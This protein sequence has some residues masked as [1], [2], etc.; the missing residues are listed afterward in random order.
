MEDGNTSPGGSGWAECSSRALSTSSGSFFTH[1][2]AL[3]QGYK[4]IQGTCSHLASP[5]ALPHKDALPK[6]QPCDSP[7][8]HVDGTWPHVDGTRRTWGTGTAVPLH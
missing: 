1:A 6:G 4:Y 8:S 7:T 3:S 2:P 5:R